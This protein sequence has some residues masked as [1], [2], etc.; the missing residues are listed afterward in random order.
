MLQNKKSNTSNTN[1]VTDSEHKLLYN[2]SAFSYNQTASSFKEIQKKEEKIISNFSPIIK[3][4]PIY[5]SNIYKNSFDI[6][7]NNFKAFIPFLNNVKI[8]IKTLLGDAIDI[9]CEP[10]DT[11]ENIKSKIYNKEMIVD[12]TYKRTKL[13]I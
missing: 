10:G 4:I 2:N 8:F 7:N 6:I 11:I 5:N 1:S 12:H 13:A 9:D 3:P